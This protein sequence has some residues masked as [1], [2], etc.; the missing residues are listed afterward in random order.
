[1]NDAEMNR[2]K[3]KIVKEM[4]CKIVQIPQMIKR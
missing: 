4:N 2:K 1:M 3:T